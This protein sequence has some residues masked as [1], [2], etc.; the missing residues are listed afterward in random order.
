[1]YT[2]GTTGRAKGVMLS[3]RNLYACSRSSHEASQAEGITRA[4]TPLPLSH[5]YGMIV[6]LTGFHATERGLAVLQRWF[7]PA[8]LLALA[9]RHRIQR[10]ALVP[11][12][13]QM[14]LAQ[15]LEDVDLSSLRYVKQ[16]RRPARGGD[17]GAVGAAGSQLPDTGGLRVHRV[18][19][20]DLGEPGRGPPG[21]LGRAAD[22]RLPGR[23]PGR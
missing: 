18:G 10:M 7:D 9:E 3:H 11:A 23:D 4:L 8:E 16:R 12:M 2:G 14:L 17:P 15:P 20:G 6:T 1:M 5:A 19:R 22:P 21:R 13:I